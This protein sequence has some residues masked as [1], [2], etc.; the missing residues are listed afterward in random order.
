LANALTKVGARPPPFSGRI[1][2]QKLH[3][4]RSVVSRRGGRW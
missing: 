1:G 3:G 4:A 2:R